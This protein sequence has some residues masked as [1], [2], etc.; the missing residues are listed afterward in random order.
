M[1]F[2][3][4]KLV[5]EKAE[6]PEIKIANICW[7][8]GKAREFQKNIYFYFIDYAKACDWSSDVCSSDLFHQEAF[9]FLFTFCHKGGEIGRA[10]VWTPV[11]G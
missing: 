11:T 8:I 7:I 2:Q 1:K 9:E 6:E 5:L 4:F 3:M 10:H